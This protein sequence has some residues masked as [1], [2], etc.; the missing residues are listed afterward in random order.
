MRQFALLLTR[1]SARRTWYNGTCRSRRAG[2]STHHDPLAS[3]LAPLITFACRRACDLAG[4]H[5][6]NPPLVRLW[7]EHYRGHSGFAR[8]LSSED[9]LTAATADCRGAPSV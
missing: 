7:S 1:Y 3:I 5:P 8:R 2:I 6:P 9:Q 4:H